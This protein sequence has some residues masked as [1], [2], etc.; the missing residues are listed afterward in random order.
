MLTNKRITI[1]ADTVIDCAKIATYGAV[2]NVDNMEMELTS[3]HIDKEAC[4][5]Y[6]DM[7]RADQA[8]FEDA[9]YDIQELLSSMAIADQPVIEE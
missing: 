2:I 5:T 7:I 6:R 4:K 1:L 9:A 3:R 8:E